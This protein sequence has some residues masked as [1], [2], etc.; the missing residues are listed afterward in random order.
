MPIQKPVAI[1]LFFYGALVA[2]LGVRGFQ[3]AGS[4]ASLY[5]GLFFGL[6]SLAGS[7]L[8]L[9]EKNIGCYLGAFTSFCLAVAFC[10]RFRVT[11]SFM[12][13]AMALLSFIVLISMIYQI[14]QINRFR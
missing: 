8:M 4:H 9:L 2:V 6:L 3:A 11:H 12:P 7:I 5:S 1:L 10:V 14:Y 13:A